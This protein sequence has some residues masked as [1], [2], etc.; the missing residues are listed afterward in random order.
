MLSEDDWSDRGEAKKDGQTGEMHHTSPFV[1][2]VYQ[3]AIA[4]STSAYLI[5]V[6]KRRIMCF[7]S[8]NVTSFL[9]F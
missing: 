3:I 7:S 6:R 4:I 1:I 2:L 8:F 5:E 9:I